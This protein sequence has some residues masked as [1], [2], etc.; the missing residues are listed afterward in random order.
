M[1]TLDLSRADFLDWLGRNAQAQVSHA[2]ARDLSGRGEISIV[3][4]NGDE[5]DEPI[6]AVPAADLRDFLAFVSTYVGSHV[7][8]TAFFRVLAKEIVDVLPRAGASSGHDVF[9]ALLGATIADAAS[10]LGSAA[11]RGSDISIQACLAT[12]SATIVTATKLGY[13]NDVA[14]VALD[15]W[16]SA[17]QELGA[18]PPRIPA[19]RMHAFWSA[20]L[21]VLNPAGG[22]PSRDVS[23]EQT[24]FLEGVR[25][26]QSGAPENALD[27]SSLWVA[28]ARGLGMMLRGS[29]EDRVRGLDALRNTLAHGTAPLE[30]REMLLGYAAAQ[31]AEGSLSYLQL[32][33][34]YADE[35]PLSLLWFGVF[36]G[37]HRNNDI[38]TAG[39]CLGRRIARHLRHPVGRLPSVSADIGFEE[40]RLFNAE[41]R[42]SKLRTDQQ[43]VIEVELLP[44]VPGRFR[45][46]RNVRRDDE[47]RRDDDSRPTVALAEAKRLVAQLSTLLKDAEAPSTAAPGPLFEKR[48]VPAPATTKVKQTRRKPK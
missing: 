33:S 38:L 2:P 24:Q 36:S 41:G 1:R 35:F 23:A 28:D 16:H 21:A 26:D 20:A 43:S 39:D 32:A 46:G 29:R 5:A 42:L 7:P 4:L 34:R 3:W 48:S 25:Y 27:R 9:A 17:R 12:S 19:A 44:G 22:L 30:M 13:D 40:F 11:S 45:F 6:I 8:F 14:L 31:V 37:L 15:R 18:G 47:V 10:Q